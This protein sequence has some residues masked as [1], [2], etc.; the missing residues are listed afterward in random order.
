MAV[1]ILST[2]TFFFNYI[3]A[4]SW[5]TRN[6]KLENRQAGKGKNKKS[7]RWRKEKAS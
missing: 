2:L 5:F 1:F 7:I 4:R 3:N 6:S